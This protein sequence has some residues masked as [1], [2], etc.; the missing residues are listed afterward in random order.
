[1]YIRYQFYTVLY[2]LFLFVLISHH[3][4]DCSPLKF[5]FYMCSKLF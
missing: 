4:V 2:I 3:L 1:M 5:Y